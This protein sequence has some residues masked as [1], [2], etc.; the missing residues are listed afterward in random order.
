MLVHSPVL[1]RLAVV[2]CICRRAFPLHRAV[3]PPI[4]MPPHAQLQPS[5]TPSSRCYPMPP[6]SM[7]TGAVFSYASCRIPTHSIARH[8][9]CSRSIPPHLVLIPIPPI[10]RQ[11]AC[12][13]FHITGPASYPPH[14][15]MPPLPAPLSLHVVPHYLAI[16]MPPPQ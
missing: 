15:T 16:P 3:S 13:C 10:E 5:I 6:L 4:P 14:P 8:T 7:Q 1:S 11:L 12:I 2:F 9:Q